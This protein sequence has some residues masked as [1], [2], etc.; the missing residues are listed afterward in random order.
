MSVTLGDEHRLKVFE[1]TVLMRMF[2]SKTK[3]VTGGW[4]KCVTRTCKICIIHQI[5][6]K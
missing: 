1:K 5:L 3:E 4:V 2:I 6:L